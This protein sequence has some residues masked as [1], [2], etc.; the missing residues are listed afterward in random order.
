MYTNF[1]IERVNTGLIN[2]TWHIKNDEKD[3]ILQKINPLV[4]KNPEAIASNVRMIS[5]YLLKNN[6]QY[7]FVS[8]IKTKKHEE[9]IQIENSYFRLTPF[10]KNS[11]TIATVEKPQQAFEA[12]RQ[13]GLFTKLLSDFPV[14]KLKTTLT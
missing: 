2:Q 13:F 10:V 7:L 1:E 11:H 4:F 5:D 12:A 8:P 6:P 3:F 9:Y 14:E